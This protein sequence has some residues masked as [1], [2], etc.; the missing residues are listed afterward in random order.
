MKK[1]WLNSLILCICLLG[2]LSAD[3]LFAS[4]TQYNAVNTP[5]NI[6]V[7]ET[8]PQ[9]IDDLYYNNNSLFVVDSTGKNI[10]KID[11]DTDEQTIVFN[12]ND[13]VPFDIVISNE[14]LI[15]S[16][17]NMFVYIV[18]LNNDNAS[19]SFSQEIRYYYNNGETSG[20]T[21][22][23]RKVVA[24]ATGEVY[25]IWDSV[26]ARLDL[27]NDRLEH[28]ATLNYDEQNLTF[29]DGEFFV[30]E[31]NSTIYF[32]IENSIYSLDTN[33]KNITLLDNST[34]ANPNQI[35]FLTFDNLGN[36]Y[37][38]DGSTLIK[39]NTTGTE[40]VTLSDINNIEINLETGQVYTANTNQLYLTTIIDDAGNPFILGYK[41][42]PAPVDLNDIEISNEL[43][44]I[45]E[46]N[47]ETNLYTYKSLQFTTTT[48]E[49][50]KKLIVLDESDSNFYY[51]Y[52]S[53]FADSEFGYMLG[54]VLKDDFNICPNTLPSDFV[55]SQ[56][57][58]IIVQESKVFVLPTSLNIDADTKAKFA[59]KLDYN[60]IV[61]I[62]SAPI[63]PTDAENV[64]FYAIRL[65]I[66]DQEVIGYI[67][68]RT[69]INVQDETLPNTPVA[70]A[71]T[72]AETIVYLEETCETEIETIP[73]G[74]NVRIISSADGVSHIQ[75]FIEQDGQTI[76]KEGYVRTSFLDDGT[77]TLT[78]ILGI[79]LMI[80]S[81][82][83]AI[84]IAI[85]INRNKKKK[86]ESNS[87]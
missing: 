64:A 75:Y 59:T 85:V 33:T 24:S 81:I 36:A 37:I 49:I 22:T 76:I 41:N 87:L 15:I 42:E 80:L 7:N 25:F 55:S 19:E 34:L 77:L 12:D 20:L 57:G 71:T 26:I 65:T 1:F 3:T 67:D 32:T 74:T 66:D 51:V 83:I 70:N 43:V 58:K 52:D 13:I 9:S 63:M 38:L 60:T 56:Q 78:Q 84:I 27:E 18:D 4:G 79:V 40:T 5:I 53:N 30:T 44:K 17:N 68:S 39:A 31:D 23:N 61:T 21:S 16:S 29:T 73:Q 11:L 48:Y 28:F 46:A 14:Q 69:V 54:Y 35:D 62:I 10:F 2:C 47:T 82:I 50:G 6:S 72:R 45:I 86:E 8:T